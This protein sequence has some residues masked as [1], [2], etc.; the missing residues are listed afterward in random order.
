MSTR[1][2]GSRPSDSSA[3]ERRVSTPF[4]VRDDIL[5]LIRDR[6][7]GPGDQ[8]P[9]EAEICRTFGVGRSTAREAFK[10]LE[11]AG[12]VTAAQGRGRFVAV[13]ASVQVER[14]VTKYES[15]SEML[16][17]QGIDAVTSVLSVEEQQAN[18]YLVEVLGLAEGD[19]V[20]RTVRLRSVDDQPLILSVNA[21]PRRLIPGP[22]AHQNWSRSITQILANH[23]HLV[24]SSAANISAV[25]LPADLSEPFSL[26]SH[27]PWLLVREQCL[28][29]S[30]ALVLYA[31]DYHWGPRFSYQVAR[32]R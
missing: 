16:A 5:A 27:A 10:L 24:V 25:D 19:A 1:A 32:H 9:S 11:Q 28:T 23:G 4:K 3:S 13:A 29:Q 31:E 21:I 7:L 14:P 2:N 8:I 12:Y 22:V 17:A 15:I 18:R 30:G 6:G 26:P 20:V